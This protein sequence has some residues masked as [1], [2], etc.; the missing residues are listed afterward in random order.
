ML[1]DEE[2]GKLKAVLQFRIDSGD[3]VLRSHLESCGCNATY[4]SKTSQN[5]LLE[6]MGDAL[7]AEL[8]RDIKDSHYYAVLADK[9]TDVSGWEQLGVAIRFIKNGVAKEKLMKF[10]ECKSIRGENL[11]RLLFDIL[12][13]MGLDP[14][15]SR[16]QGH[17]G[18]ANM[19]GQFNGC[20]AVF[21]QTAPLASYFHCGSHQ[22]NLVLTK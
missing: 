2:Q 20:Q 6:C 8:L 16:A 12:I 14:Q 18:E 7:R 11:S 3:E 15:L 10:V 21:K 9:V 4:I 19:S 22:L 5:D 17:D 13:S 1:T